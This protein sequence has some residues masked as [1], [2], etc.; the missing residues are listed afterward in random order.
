M[1]VVLLMKVDSCIGTEGTKINGVFKG[2]KK[3]SGGGV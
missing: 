3:I 1:C 2:I